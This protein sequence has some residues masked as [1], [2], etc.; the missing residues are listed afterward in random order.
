M[1]PVLI[2]FGYLPAVLVVKTVLLKR[3]LTSR[4]GFHQKP[5]FCDHSRKSCDHKMAGAGAWVDSTLLGV[6]E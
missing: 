2:V 1:R 4:A 3:F 5:V 6:I